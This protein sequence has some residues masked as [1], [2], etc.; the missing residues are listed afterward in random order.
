MTAGDL[1]ALELDAEAIT[2]SEAQPTTP[3]FRAKCPALLVS[4]E[5]PGHAVEESLFDCPSAGAANV[6]GI[7]S[8]NTRFGEPASVSSSTSAE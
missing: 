7:F 1:A 8:A 5:A 6:E 4:R 3:S 2:D